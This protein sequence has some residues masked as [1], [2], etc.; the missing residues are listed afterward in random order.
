MVEIEL[1]YSEETK[2][3]VGRL[4]YDQIIFFS[5]LLVFSFM[6]INIITNTISIVIIVILNTLFI[7]TPFIFKLINIKT[8]AS[9]HYDSKLNAVVVKT[10]RWKGHILPETYLVLITRKIGNNYYVYHG[11]IGINIPKKCIVLT[12]KGYKT[13]VSLYDK[14][15]D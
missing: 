3:V 4:V 5:L 15:I 6:N 13:W 1:S 7:I 12:D 9:C 8:R 14:L 2:T 11:D 10:P